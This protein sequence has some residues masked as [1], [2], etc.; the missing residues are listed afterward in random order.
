MSSRATVTVNIRDVNDNPPMFTDTLDTIM[1][2]E[3]SQIGVPL[4]IVTTMDD[5]E[6]GTPNSMIIFVITGGSGSDVFDIDPNTGV[7][8]LAASLDFEN[9]SLYT[10]EVTAEDLGTPTLSTSRNLTIVVLNADD[11]VPRFLQGAYQFTLFENNDV[12]VAV[13]TVEARDLDLGDREIG[14]ALQSNDSIPFRINNATGEI[15]ATEV[16]NRE[17]VGSPPQY[18]FTATAFYMDTPDNVTSTAQVII[19]IRDVNDNGVIIN[20]FE[21]DIVDEDIQQDA[22]V[23]RVIATDLDPTSNLTYQISVSRNLLRISQTGL[24]RFIL[25]NTDIDRESLSNCPQQVEAPAGARC[26]PVILRIT[27]LTSG[28]STAD[29]DYLIVRDLDDEP[30]VFNQPS[31]SITIRENSSVGMELSGLGIGATDPDFNVTLRYSIPDSVSAFE[32][33]E[34]SGVMEVNEVLDFETT[35]NYTFPVVVEDG[36]GNRATAD[37]TIWITDVN[38]NT[39]I[40]SQDSYNATISETYPVGNVLAMV[41]ATDLD[42]TTNQVISFNIAAGNLGNTF[43]IDSRFGD[44]ILAR[45]LDRE[46]VSEYDLTIEAV[47]G[48]Y[49]PN[50]ATSSLL[51]TITDVSDSVPYFTSPAY[52]GSVSET[53]Q[54]GDLVLDSNGQPLVVTFMDDDVDDVVTIMVLNPTTPILVDQTTGSVT[55]SGA[56][57]FEQES[58]YEIYMVLRDAANLFSPPATLTINILPSNDHRP[59]FQQQN[60]ALSL[61]ENSQNGE[62]VLRV[63]ADDV[64]IGDVVTYELLPTFSALDRFDFMP[65]VT[66]PFTIDNS[67]G[68]I[69][70]T[71]ALDFETVTRW[72]FTVLATDTGGLTDSTTVTVTVQDTNDNPPEF[73]MDPFN[74]TLP[75]NFTVGGPEP[76]SSVISASDVDTV[77]VLQ[78]FILSGAEGR[79]RLD[80]GNALLYVVGSLEAGATYNMQVRV[81]DGV[82]SDTATVSIYVR[83]IND[84]APVFLQDSYSASIPENA[85][86]STFV[87]QVEASD[88]DLDSLASI[89]Y[90]I[91]P[92]ENSSFFRV[93]PSSG[94]IFTNTEGFDFD[95]PPREYVIAVQAADGGSPPRTAVVDV[96]ITLLDVDDIPQ[97]PAAPFFLVDTYTATVQEN[98]GAG[99]SLLRVTAEDTNEGDMLEYSI[100]EEYDSTLLPTPEPASG[101]FFSSGY[102]GLDPTSFPFSIDR[103]SGDIYLDQELDYEFLTQWNFTVFAIDNAGLNATVSVVV[104]V[105]DLNDNAPRFDSHIFDIYLPENTTASREVEASNDIRATDLDSVS[106]LRYFILSGAQGVF[107]MNPDTG[108]LYVVA[109]LDP[110]QVYIMR[111]LV[112]DGELDDQAV[113]EVRIVDVNNNGPMFLQNEYI[114]FISEDVDIGSSVVRVEAVDRD[115]GVFA[116]IEYFVESPS[117]LFRV[118]SATG[119]IYTAG[120]LDYDEPPRVYTLIVS[121]TDGGDEPRSASVNVTV[122]L[123]DFNDNAPEFTSSDSVLVDE[124]TPIGTSV[125]Q[126]TASDIDSNENSRLEFAISPSPGDFSIERTTGIIRVAQELDF[127]GVNATTDYELNITITDQGTPSLSSSGILDIFITDTNDNAPYFSDNII[128][129]LVPE[130]TSIDGVA[131]TIDEAFDDDSSPNNILSYSIISANPEICL[132]RFRV[133]GNTNVVRLNE[134]LDAE[135]REVPCTLIVRATDAG[136]PPLSGQSTYLVIITD[137]NEHRPV[138]VPSSLM[139]SVPENS[140]PGSTVTVLMSTDLDPSPVV[141]RSVGGV[142][143]EDFTVSLD[144]TVTVANG[145]SLDRERMNQYTIEI[146]VAEESALP[147]LMTRGF[148]VIDI[149]DLNDNAPQFNQSLY[150]VSVREVHPLLTPPV[151]TVLATDDDIPPNDDITYTFIPN[152]MGDTDYNTFGIDESGNIYLT[153]SLDFDSGPRFY[154]LRVQASDG[155]MTDEASVNVRV[156]ESNDMTPQFVN[157]PSSV[158]IPENATD[159]STVT[160]VMAVDNDQSINGEIS[161][162]LTDPSGKFDINATSGVI[163]V[164][165]DGQFDFES[166]TKQYQVTVFAM[167]RTGMD[168]DNAERG[169]GFGEEPFINPADQQRMTSENLTVFITDV[170][171]NAPQFTMPGG[172]N[173]LTVEHTAISLP[174][175]NVEASDADQPNTDNSVVR[176]RIS[177]I[178]C[179]SSECGTP[180]TIDPITGAVNTVPPID[181]EM[182]EGYSIIIQAYDLGVP[183]MSTDVTLS[184]VVIDTNDNRPFFPQ[185]NYTGAIFENSPQ[186]SP[187]FVAVDNI[188]TAPPLVVT[189]ID[190]DTANSTGN[191]TYALFDAMNLFQIDPLSGAITA[192]STNIDRERI[193]NIVFRAQAQDTSGF[194]AETTIFVT[195]LDRNDE[196]PIF[197]QGSYAFSNTE[198]TPVGATLGGVRARD[199][200]Q[201]SNAM[202]LYSISPGVPY[203]AINADTGVITVA[204]SVCLNSTSG[205]VTSVN[206]TAQDALDATLYSTVS[207]EITITEENINSP[208]FVQPSYISRLDAE[209]SR[210][211]EIIPNLRTK[212][213]DI[214]SGPPVFEIVSGNTNDTFAI[215]SDT[216]R[217]VLTRNLTSNDIGFT[218]VVRAT[219]TANSNPS[220]DLSM[221]VTVIVLV[222]Q[223]L[224]VSIAVDGGYTVP[225][226][227][228]IAT[229]QYEQNVWIHN[230]GT[231][232]S[233]PAT[234]TYSLG[235]ISVNATIPKAAPSAVSV[236]GTIA[237]R[238]IYVNDPY[239]RVAAQVEGEQFEKASLQPTQVLVSVVNEP[240]SVILQGSCTTSPPSA[241][242]V[243]EVE[244]PEDAFNEVLSANVSYGISVDSMTVA[245]VVESVPSVSCQVSSGDQVRVDLPQRVFYPGD[246]F[247]VS[248]SSVTQYPTDYFSITFETSADLMFDS[249]VSSSA[250]YAVTSSYSEARFI[251]S[252]L[253]SSGAD[254]TQGS[255]S[256]FINFQLRVSPDAQLMGYGLANVNATVDYMIDGRGMLTLSDTP[257]YHTGLEQNMTCSYSGQV[258]IAENSIARV[259]SFSP[260]SSLLNTAPLD[261]EDVSVMF[262]T[263]AL[264]SSGELTRDI[265]ELGCSSQ[266][267]T[268]LQVRPDCSMVYVN[269]TGNTGQGEVEIYMSTASSVFSSSFVVWYPTTVLM[270][271][272]VDV[273]SPLENVYD[274]T[275]S[276]CVQAYESATIEVAALF[277]AGTSSQFVSILPLVVDQLEISDPSVLRVA[278]RSNQISVV[279]TAPGTARVQ[280]GEYSSGNITV[281]AEAVSI[282][283]ITFSLHSDL[284]PTPLSAASPGMSYLQTTVVEIESFFNRLHTELDVLVEAVL[285]NGRNYELTETNGFQLRSTDDEII[286]V[287]GSQVTVR[288]SGTGQILVGEID[289]STCTG[290]A[291]SRMEF[292]E[293]ELSPVVAVD[294]SLGSITLSLEEFSDMLSIPSATSIS[295]DLVHEDWSR[296]SLATTDPRVQ[297]VHDEPLL[298][299]EGSVDVSQ[300][301]SAG[302][303]NFTVLYVEG[304]RNVSSP[305]I[306]VEVIGVNEVILTASSY[307]ANSGGDDTVMERFEGTY[308]YQQLELTLTALISDGTALDVTNSNYTSFT[309]SDAFIATV[310]NVVTGISP[311]NATINA[312]FGSVM[313]EIT[314]EVTDD[315]VFVVDILPLSLLLD[316]GILRGYQGQAFTPEV[317]VVFSDDTRY[318]NFLT[319]SG[320]AVPD[321][322]QFEVDSDAVFIGNTSG[323][324]VRNSLEQVTLTVSREQ[325]MET[326]SFQVDLL[327][328]VGEVDIEGFTRSTGVTDVEVYLNAEG[329]SVGVIELVLGTSTSGVEL[330]TLPGSSLAHVTP[331]TDVPDS[332]ISVVPFNNDPSYTKFGFLF[333]EPVIGTSRLHIA[334]L[335]YNVVRTDFNFSI[336][337]LNVNN[338]S[339]TYSPIGAPTSRYSP[340]ADIGAPGVT[341]ALI[342]TPRCASLPCTPRECTAGSFPTGDANADCSFDLLDAYFTLEMIPQLQL[343]TGQTSNLLPEQLRAMD[344]DWNGVI[345][346]ADVRLLADAAV[347]LYPLI[348][349]LT[350][351]PI[352]AADSDCVMTISATLSGY[353]NLPSYVYFGIFHRD[354][355]FDAQFDSTT[356]ARGTKSATTNLPGGAF[357]GW[358]QAEQ[359]E[360]RFVMRTNSGPIAQTGIGLFIMYGSQ[361]D[362]GV[363]SIERTVTL[364]GVQTSSP[365]YGQFTASFRPFSGQTVQLDFISS[366]PLLTF[367]N[368]FQGDI[369]PNLFPPVINP[370]IGDPLVRTQSESLANGTVLVSGIDA[371][372]G[373][374]DVPAG[375]LLFSLDSV[376][377]PGAIDI[378]PSS[379]AIFVSGTLDRESYAFLSARIVV[380][381]QG[382]HIPTRM[383]DSIG[384]T[385]FLIDFNDNPPLAMLPRI[386]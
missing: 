184:V 270:S 96:T 245:G 349:D 47:D 130:N 99:T 256:F 238:R 338:G 343:G 340:P 125:F 18:S 175:I 266:D 255:H 232:R 215:D 297:F 107:E 287:S 79:F 172:Y 153:Q 318:P 4:G 134:Q 225:P 195:I 372:D 303:V 376:S 137:I 334:T 277:S 286:I 95:Q 279:G 210:D 102:S 370:S 202:T 69:S 16:I 326:L 315:E 246:Y 61:M 259:F 90:S 73:D 162:S 93:E 189:A 224:P 337:I 205:L 204:N 197:E 108:G 1:V 317:T 39:P 327:P 146:E 77:G 342:D 117:E 32:I 190:R 148:L 216:G 60:Y 109:P 250:E 377:A 284:V 253:H 14:Y 348:S 122:N 151:V 293:I 316:N 133:E 173:A 355:S 385:L 220:L 136:S 360:D 341:D 6:P 323:T 235:N 321:L 34:L 363:V 164:R 142:G 129:K 19:T 186:G 48:G 312:T 386:M 242:C 319:P 239:V 119:V 161:Y 254:T 325:I 263:I 289:R 211:T 112:T 155:E 290:P 227:R 271:S 353:F 65:D 58:V 275:G 120:E 110:R 43:E 20:T 97:V 182:N 339:G 200:D 17:A 55:V 268:V 86:N 381:D 28:N 308:Q 217:I 57:D 98:S 375:G 209:A 352:D 361:I 226:I 88:M 82:G 378:N 380:T 91:L 193:Q 368:S 244:M 212:D 24:P 230:G 36:G 115:L 104:R 174:V 83:D 359:V 27:D 345:D 127:D 44:V 45:S 59:M 64:D 50:T 324:L 206:V 158:M 331:G 171:D 240:L 369:C 169:S 135:E 234:I 292:I 143:I 347:L 66:L 123:E 185:L 272:E 74:I 264:L 221:N 126:V 207:L 329:C 374:G 203:F 180:F 218:L 131:F 128:Q 181:R 176:Y 198:N 294:V 9:L 251:L 159:G 116:D 140:P 285:S 7:I 154:Y 94:R 170:N 320:P 89:T 177:S 354:A 10:V 157:F 15:F 330:Q 192:S 25:T 111:I 22:V 208:V 382:P 281:T 335:R 344:A 29:F 213:Q 80:P 38:D 366:N 309:T 351:V 252:G 53:A 81:T 35:T 106:T 145:T 296:T 383:N 229:T 283:D 156:L 288:G 222:G 76:A 78:Y 144:G 31:Y 42:S 26:I 199:G 5:D 236:T 299:G 265:P 301:S 262:N 72:V 362:L 105:E 357:G 364:T 356:L 46:T 302:A 178:S 40:F 276:E 114:V 150:L 165:G 85:T 300:L 367:N 21:L 228:R 149:S 237:Q 358:V 62:E 2:S 311:V 70:L 257:A 267:S 249:I 100:M 191:L 187:V 33:Q 332:A 322:L 243:A 8:T 313:D 365:E 194:F 291:L 71:R 241:T 3:D 278:E 23:G 282:E 11:N 124:D 219:D 54:P 121:A 138:F 52:E 269:A 41:S 101:D 56:L 139:A 298:F 113:A 168:S 223:L 346:Q 274:T 248:V 166:P 188:E 295:I 371:T 67:T 336:L 201:G 314:V 333:P 328:R 379:G 92:S 258:L 304:E 306:V 273:L 84:N 280:F 87:V 305:N 307:P 68:W 118:D 260:T 152:S 196:A 163:F 233:D 167:D 384:F 51:V 132:G 247:D 75:E 12:S 310:G 350:V 231:V 147:P 49:P 13:G 183:S 160:Q 179:S 37:V 373:D 141:Y 214:C 30:P 103:Y 261:G 63:I